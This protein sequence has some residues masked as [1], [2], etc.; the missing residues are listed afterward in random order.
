[1]S[2]VQVEADEVRTCRPTLRY[3]T[4]PTALQRLE[5]GPE[6]LEFKCLFLYYTGLSLQHSADL[7]SQLS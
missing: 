6:P 5:E 3:I 7:Q 4:Q 2:Y 1:M